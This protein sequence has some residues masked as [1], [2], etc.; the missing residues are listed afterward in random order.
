MGII[1]HYYLHILIL[2]FITLGNA[3]ETMKGAGEGLDLLSIFLRVEL[4]Y[5]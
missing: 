4:E 1:I 2:F 3:G 5:I